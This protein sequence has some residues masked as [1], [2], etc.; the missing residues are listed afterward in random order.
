MTRSQLSQVT[1][2]QK[3]ND[4]LASECDRLKTKLAETRSHLETLQ[5]ENDRL[6]QSESRY[7]QIFE[8]A[9][10]SMLS[11]NTD[12][13]ITQMNAAAE[14]L[15]GLP[16]DQLNQQGS[17]IFDN[18]Q[19]VENGALPRMLQAFSGET[20][21]VSCAD[22]YDSSRNFVTGHSF[23]SK[24][25]YCPIRDESGTVQEI[26]EIAPD[27]SDLLAAQQALQAER[28]RAAQ[29]R[30]QL[31]S[32]IAEVANLLLRSPDYTAV[33]PDVVRLLGEAVGSDRCGI[34]QNITHP[35]LG[36]AATQITPEWCRA[37]VLH[38]REF[39]PNPDQLF[40]WE[41]DA[42]YLHAELLQGRVINSLVANLPEP[43]R[44]LLIAQGNVAELFVPILV[45]NQCWGYIA[46]DNCGES[47]P[48]GEAEI[49][50]LK[51]AADSV[52]AAIERQAKDD[53][54]RKSEALYRS[55]FEISNEGIYYCEFSPPLPVDLP[56]AE[57][58]EQYYQSLCL[59]KANDTFAQMYGL[60]KGEDIIGLKLNDV[61]IEASEKNQA[62]IRA[63]VENG[64]RI[65][66]M[67][68]EEIDTQGRKRYF[69]N[70]VINQ[71]ENGGAVGSW[72]TQIDI[73]ELREAQQALLQAEQE[74]SQEL[75]RLN[76]ELQQ[77][78]DRLSESERYYRI[79]FELSNEG[80]YQFE[81]EPIPLSLPIKQQIEMAYQSLRIAKVNT[82]FIHQYG[83]DNAEDITGLKFTDFYPESSEKGRQAIQTLIENHQIRGIE[84]E[85]VNGR[86]RVH[87]SLASLNLRI[88]H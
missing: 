2:L 87:P 81:V 5:Q 84:T 48:Y 36:K 43:E 63:I 33:L 54:L 83:F 8:N 50:I 1:E 16:I 15:F 4:R 3:A 82:S 60:E 78:I 6:R 29:E 13:Y 49:A 79:L 31:L 20:A 75:E 80:I 66:N 59:T 34:G 25:H 39:S 28:D 10:I 46:F 35:T 27:F 53:E 47:R 56:V 37:T 21:V 88:A 41:E 19:L 23:F 57:Q 58:V 76:G 70:S 74:R 11:I 42:P 69:L 22:Y 73:T 77:A 7:R 68:S 61:H 52:A 40:V 9:P 30:A 71:I 62:F 86:G 44:S 65:R 24:G 55:L 32:T 45:S 14:D 85:E 67:E 51:I 17:P 38:S 12:G 26:V 72:G 18:R 64:H